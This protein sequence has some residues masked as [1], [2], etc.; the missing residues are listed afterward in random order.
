MMIRTLV[1]EDDPTLAAAHLGFVE[2][3]QG[4]EPAGIAHSGREALRFIGRNRP[5]LI[6]L[7]FGLPDMNGLDVCRSLR[8]GAGRS[9]DVIAVTSA[10]D[11]ETIHHAIAHGV[12]QY[13]IK[14]FMPSSLR[15]RL[16]RYAEYR[17]RLTSSRG[18]AAQ[19]DVDLLFAALR[20]SRSEPLPKGLTTDSWRAVARVV[21]DAERPLSSTHVAEAAGL[22]RVTARRY[23]E[24]LV[25]Q[26]LV[27]RSLRYGGGRPEQLYHWAARG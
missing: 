2:A 19:Q 14:P 17:Q 6:L 3:V 26:E 8:S 24:H 23:L 27:T 9:V 13:L 4:F 22:S 25:T 16:E 21:R 11:V 12:T 15:E 7:D 1:V 5:D 18:L 10:R 20:G